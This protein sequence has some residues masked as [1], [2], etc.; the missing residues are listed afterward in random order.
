MGVA[1]ADWSGDG[2]P[3]L[4]VSNSR[5]QRHAAFRSDGG[6]FRDA[7]RPFAAALGTDATGW[8]VSW[9]DLD[10]DGDLDLVMADGAIPVTNVTKDART[11]RVIGNV[12]GQFADV[13]RLVGTAAAGRVNGRGTAAAD[14]DN[15]GRVD[16]AVNSIGGRL[17]LLRN[18][19]PRAHW[20]EVGLRRFAPGAT[21]T[22]V[23]PDGR[24]LVREV[25]AGSSYLS[26][27]DP[28]V[29]FGLGDAAHV[30]ELTVRYPDGA[31]VRMR[32]VTADQRLRIRAANP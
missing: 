22:A 20:L 4:V 9:A 28:R 25:Q 19:G 17:M 27:E 3:D 7:R 32:N 30:A 16:V 6:S 21:V 23:L 2:R 8:G 5:G 10:L 29:H 15:D 26:S 31:T 24:R 14:F 11:V 1:T 13:S 18:T 12:D